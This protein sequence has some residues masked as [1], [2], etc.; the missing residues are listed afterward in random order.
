MDAFI[1]K[2]KSHVKTLTQ[3]V[4]QVIARKKEKFMLQSPNFWQSKKDSIREIIVKHGDMSKQ[5]H[6]CVKV[7]ISKVTPFFLYMLCICPSHAFMAGVFIDSECIH[8]CTLL[9][10]RVL[11]SL[12]WKHVVHCGHSTDVLLAW[13]SY[14]DEAS[15]PH[16]KR[17][18]S[19]CFKCTTMESL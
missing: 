7:C 15:L 13:C 3:H 2:V 9:A 17:P 14:R 4:H 8:S 11:A 12:L 16:K 19:S 18:D 10:V 5:R 6:P 1:G